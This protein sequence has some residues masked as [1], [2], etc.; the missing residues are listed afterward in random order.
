MWHCY[1]FVQDPLEAEDSEVE[2]ADA[3][4]K[5][6]KVRHVPALNSGRSASQRQWVKVL[7]SFAL[8]FIALSY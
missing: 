1:F 5:R 7:S 4:V 6:R 2:E 3:I 8:C